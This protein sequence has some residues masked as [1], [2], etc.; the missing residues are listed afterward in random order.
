MLAETITEQPSFLNFIRQSKSIRRYLVIALAAIILQLVIFKLFYPFASFFFTDSFGYLYAAG[1]NLDAY[2]WPIGYSKFLRVFNTFFHSDTAL[3]CFQYVFLQ[4]AS[5]YFLF[6]LLYL[7]RPPKPVAG[8]LFVIMVVSP[9]SLY[10]ANSVSS[11]AL[12]IGLSLLWMAQLMQLTGNPSRRRIAIHTVLLALLFTIRYTA[13]YYPIVSGIAILFSAH[14]R[15]EKALA[16]TLPLLLIAA[17]IYGTAL[18]NKE[19]T[20]IRQFSPFSGWQL[21]NNA[22]YMYGH[23]RPAPGPVPASSPGQTNSP[24]Q[25]KAPVAREPVPA[26]FAALDAQVRRYFDTTRRE[27]TL[28]D[29]LYPGDF[30]LWSPQS[31]LAGYQGLQEAKD[32]AASYYKKW[33]T[34]SALYGDYGSWLIA[35]HPLAYAQYYCWPNLQRY[36]LPPLEFMARYNSGMDT[37]DRLTVAWFHYKDQRVKAFSPKIQASILAPYP[38]L[39]LL[40]NLC[41]LGL[42]FLF[43]TTP[44]IRRA[45]PLFSRQVILIGSAWLLHLGFSVLA[46]PVVLRYQVFSMILGAAGSLLLAVQLLKGEALQEANKIAEIKT[47]K[48]ETQKNN[49]RSL[50]LLPG[51][52]IRLHRYR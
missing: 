4:A 50:R 8:I 26:R 24:D 10:L 21:A 20:G 41:W 45:D 33:G 2:I 18:A 9:F 38:A 25:P 37:V 43:L 16:I 46:A 19:M 44:V 27:R 13:I 34:F 36:A 48:D 11:D 40:I 32:S 15:Q 31:P 23:D 39:S 35:Q 12:F 28:L 42:L 30:Y 49:H 7:F 14:T 51:I 22:L 6:T 29:A 3:V 52:L 17:F 1:Y 5:L 47:T